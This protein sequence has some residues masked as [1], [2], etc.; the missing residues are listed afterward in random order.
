M[1]CTTDVVVVRAALL[2]D[3]L[4]ELPDPLCTSSLY[5]MLIDALSV[6]ASDDDVGNAQLMFSILD[7]LPAVNQVYTAHRPTKSRRHLANDRLLISLYKKL[8]YRRV[9]A[10]CVLSVVIFPVT[11]Q[12]CR[13][14]LYD[15][16]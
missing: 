1:L 7:C 11:T 5:Q 12:Q 16:S 3:Y 14:Y 6:R 10:R 8:S 15:K 2:K 4:R 13:N 9:T